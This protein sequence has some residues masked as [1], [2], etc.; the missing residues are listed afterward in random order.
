MR[1]VCAAATGFPLISEIIKTGGFT[2]ANVRVSVAP[3]G[4]AIAVCK[5]MAPCAVCT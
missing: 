5:V 1:T 4:K 3:L 2:V